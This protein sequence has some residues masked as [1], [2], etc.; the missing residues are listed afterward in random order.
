MLQREVE[1]WRGRGDGLPPPTRQSIEERGK[2]VQPP[3][4]L[5]RQPRGEAKAVESSGNSH[6]PKVA[7]IP[8]V[9]AASRDGMRNDRD[10]TSK[11]PLLF[12]AARGALGVRALRMEL[13]GFQATFL[14]WMLLRKEQPRE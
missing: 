3:V 4:V 2:L 6:R 5:T 12:P 10:A 11:K 9:L 1:K 7:E 13:R 14:A 8:V